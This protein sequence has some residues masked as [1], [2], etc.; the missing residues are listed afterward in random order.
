MFLAVLADTTWVV[1]VPETESSSRILRIVRAGGAC[2]DSAAA[3]SIM[4]T[5]L[6]PALLR[7]TN[8]RA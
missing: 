3:E 6:V 1:L 5:E 4:R 8:R 2:L 7:S